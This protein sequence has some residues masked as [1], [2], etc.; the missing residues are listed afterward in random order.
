MGDYACREQFQLLKD[1]LIPSQVF[2]LHEKECIPF[3]C[4]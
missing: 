3:H 2:E 1:T 4:S